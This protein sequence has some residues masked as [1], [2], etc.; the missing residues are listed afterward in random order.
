MHPFLHGL[1]ADVIASGKLSKAP[2]LKELHAH[3]SALK[4]S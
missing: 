3:I 2:A 1:R 4:L